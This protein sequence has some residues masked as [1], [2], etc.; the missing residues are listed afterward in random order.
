MRRSILAAALLCVAVTGALAQ[1]TVYVDL[2]RSVM[3]EPGLGVDPRVDYAAMIHLGP[4]DD[5]NYALTAEDLRVLSVDEA[6]LSDPIPVFFRVAMRKARPDLRSAGP[7]Q[8]PRSAL[9][10]FRQNY[11]GYL[12]DGRHYLGA[13]RVGDR[14]YV[15]TSQPASESA[16]T[17]LSGESRVTSPNGAAESAIKIHPTNT[18]RVI[19][20]SNGPG[21]GQKMHWSDDG[22]STWTETT[23]PLG[24]TCC[25]PA[26][27]W[28]SGGTYAYA[29]ALGSCSFS[30]G[31]W[32]YRSDDGGQTWNGLASIDGDPRRE[33]GSGDKE[34]L[35]VDTSPASPYRDNV[36]VTWHQSNVLK[37]AVSSDDGHTFSTYTFPSDSANL[38]IGSD[39]TTDSAGNVYHLWPA[40]NSRTIRL[41]KSTDGGQSFGSPSVVAATEGSFIFPLPSIETREAFIYV[42][43]DADRSGGVY[44]DSIYAA[45]TDNTGPDS[46]VPSA[47]HG[48]IQVAYSRDGGSTWS[49]TTPH[50]TADQL[51]VDRWHPWLGVGPDGTVYV[52]FYDTRRDASRT[53]VD[54]FYSYS[55]DGA[56]TWSTPERL[57]TALSPN[58]A[59]GFEF[60][61]Y[62]GL[63]IVMSQLITIFTDNREEGGGSGDS[64]DVYAAGLDTGGAVCGNDTVEP[65]EA[66]DG[67]DLNGRT[68]ADFG[69]TGGGTLTC[70]PDCSGHDTSSCL[71]CPLCDDDGTCETGEDCTNCPNDC[72]SGSSSGAV[73]GNG[74]CEAGN[75]EDC[76]T[77]AAD[78]DGKQGGKPSGR[79][80]CGFGGTNPVGCDPQRCGSCLVEPLSPGSYCCG[81]AV[82]SGGESCAN[83]ALDCTRGPE[84]CDNGIDDDC[85]N[86]TDC[87]DTT[88][89]ASAPVCQPT[90]LGQGE[91]C[92]SGDECCSGSCK[93]KR[94]IKTC[95]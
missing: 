6:Q 45:W 68:C 59:D 88:A 71:G 76:V 20:G 54:F 82:C 33:I 56:Q 67:T 66:C 55:S 90:C 28:S 9:Q 22:G 42:A 8:Y 43:A 83:C 61:D 52:A 50:E 65:G 5:R 10:M 85:A 89:C 64:I 32:V 40:F 91:L 46:G 15:D 41:A 93:G 1:Q 72:V 62:N 7:A 58:I 84:I 74:I 35:H 73:C 17:D 94:G 79:Y 39:V 75:G 38:G 29:T 70:R 34:F 69:C 16:G 77:C 95:R 4:W 60:G 23:L 14:Y 18:G 53:S 80:C 24:S 13:R 57:T 11:G 63:D 78:C 21:S 12:V 86:G 87:S 19:A 31:I 3:L 92:N 81:D 30:C 49:V 26:V 44:H 47:N 25:D 36:Y 48:R 2:E 51:S 27:D 37:L